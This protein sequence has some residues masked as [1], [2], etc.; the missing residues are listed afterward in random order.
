MSLNRGKPNAMDLR[1]RKRQAKKQDEA[2]RRVKHK[3]WLET[4]VAFHMEEELARLLQDMREKDES[5]QRVLGIDFGTGPDAMA[6][7][8]GRKLG[9]GLGIDAIVFYV[10]DGPD[11]ETLLKELGDIYDAEAG[12]R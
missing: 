7:V 5:R 11:I 4:K 8:I 9:K 6:M 10:D 3:Q 12:R 1:W 2:L